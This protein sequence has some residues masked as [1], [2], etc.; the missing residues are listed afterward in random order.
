MAWYNPL[1]WGKKRT[2][3]EIREAQLLER[4][5]QLMDNISKSLRLTGNPITRNTCIHAHTLAV[6]AK[7]TIVE[8]NT[9]LGISL[10]R[11]AE[12][13]RDEIKKGMNENIALN[14]GLDNACRGALESMEVAAK[15]LREI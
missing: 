14:P 8:L 9:N 2:Q 11:S 10:R 15:R 1:S 6:E 5:A 3:E 4:Y 7:D 13:I 12:K